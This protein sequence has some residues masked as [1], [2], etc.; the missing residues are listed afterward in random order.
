MQRCAG[1]IE[2]IVLVD[3]RDK[4]KDDMARG[5][6]RIQVPETIY[7]QSDETERSVVSPFG[8]EGVNHR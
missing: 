3:P 6:C 8:L 1:S 7:G 4:P 5:E 2:Y